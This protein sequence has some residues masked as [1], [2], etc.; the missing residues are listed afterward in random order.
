[1]II[2]NPA[3]EQAI[4][5]CSLLFKSLINTFSLECLDIFILFIDIFSPCVLMLLVAGD[6][7]EPTTFEL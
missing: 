2:D 4:V 7:F 5:N 6:G 1:M 3:L